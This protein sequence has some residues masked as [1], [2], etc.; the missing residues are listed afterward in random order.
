MDFTAIGQLAQERFG[1]KL[2]TAMRY[3]PASAEVE[4]VHT[5]DA[6]AYPLSGHKTKRDTGWSRQVLVRGEPHFAADAQAIRA[7]F[8]DAEAIFALGVGT[9]INVPVREATTGAVIGTLNFGREAGGYAPEDVARALA[10]AALAAPLF[11]A[12]R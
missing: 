4:R 7:A 3:L 6:A 5:S 8:E 10:L 9:L 11:D 2:F 12:S 1:W